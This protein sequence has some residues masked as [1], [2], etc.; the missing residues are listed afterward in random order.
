MLPHLSLR[1]PAYNKWCLGFLQPTECQLTHHQHSWSIAQ[2]KGIFTHA[3]ITQLFNW[4]AW[5]AKWNGR[6]VDSSLRWINSESR[7]LSFLPCLPSARNINQDAYKNLLFFP[8][9]GC[10]CWGFLS[11]AIIYSKPSLIETVQMNVSTALGMKLL[12]TWLHLGCLLFIATKW[13]FSM[14][15]TLDVQPVPSCLQI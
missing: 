10:C 13:V 12:P 15:W 11:H 1:P 7:E 3:I 8:I 2:W 9:Y 6:R 14:F 5:N 4:F